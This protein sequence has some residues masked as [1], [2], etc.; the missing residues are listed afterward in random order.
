MYRDYISEVRL[1]CFICLFQLGFCCFVCIASFV[2]N[3]NCVDALSII[4]K[5]VL[6]LFP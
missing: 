4:V 6:L 3:L 2:F 1:M 5:S